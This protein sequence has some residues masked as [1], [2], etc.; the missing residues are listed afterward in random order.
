MLT[1][2]LDDGGLAVSITSDLRFIT[3]KGKTM[4]DS[5][6]SKIQSCRNLILRKASPLHRKEVRSPRVRYQY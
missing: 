3:S 2:F 4:T 1:M 6:D 5:D